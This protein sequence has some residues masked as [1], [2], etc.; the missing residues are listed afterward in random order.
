M[1]LWSS[2][3]TF[4][5]NRRRTLS[6]VAGTLGGAYLLG[7][8]GLHKLEELAERSKRDRLDS[9]N[10]ARRFSLNQQDCQFTILALLPT[11]APQ[12]LG[13]MDVERR[14][15]QLA[16]LAA[17][18][19]AR[20]RQLSEQADKAEKEEM[21]KLEE[22]TLRREKELAQEEAVPVPAPA[23]PVLGGGGGG[24]ALNPAAAAFVPSFGKA[25]GKKV[26]QELE[27][28]VSV[29]T[30]TT[31][32]DSELAEST[33]ASGPPQDDGVLSKSWAQVVQ[34]SNGHP[35]ELEQTPAVES[36]AAAPE[37]EPTPE[38]TP[39]APTPTRV[40]LWTEI[41]ILSFTRTLTSL[42]L[43]TLLS[44]Q[45]HIQLN[46]LGRASYVSSVLAGLPSS[47]STSSLP[48]PAVQES[49]DDLERALLPLKSTI[50]YGEL[51]TLLGQIRQRID[52]NPDGTPFSFSPTLFPPTPTDE[53]LTLTSGGATSLSTTTSLPSSL[54]RL[55][56]ETRELTDSSDG[57]LVVEDVRELAEFS[58]IIYA[59]FDQD[60][61]RKSC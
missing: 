32:G 36:P 5:S 48:L 41:K 44:L 10:L 53:L 58:A 24:Q 12:L 57:T 47:T 43:L 38:P 1:Q 56:D 54:R 17:Q 25:A 33:E 40:E 59:S 13:A 18:V 8:W 29:P 34:G 14:S 46:L 30:P 35:E 2:V 16:Q 51:P 42:Y 50:V 6:W 19:K 39:S 37:P 27:Q 4:V 26:A 49:D 21:R 52:T 9:E 23:S 60:D 31:N 22:D 15:A 45:T 55:L 7:Q 11:V 3:Q 20:E 61:V 28:P